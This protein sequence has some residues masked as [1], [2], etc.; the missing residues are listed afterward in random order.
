METGEEGEK[1][2]KMHRS[3]D[4]A[5]RS[6]NDMRLV[7]G[8]E[9]HT[10]PRTTNFFTSTLAADAKEELT[11]FGLLDLEIYDLLKRSAA[12]AQEKKAAGGE[13]VKDDVCESFYNEKAGSRFETAGWTEEEKQQQQKLL[14][15]TVNYLELPV[16]IK[17]E[18]ANY[19]GLPQ[20]E[21]DIEFA[22]QKVDKVDESRVKLVLA[23]LHD[24]GK[25]EIKRIR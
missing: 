12:A 22:H 23:D 8:I 9:G 2:E 17:D 5:Q 25:K 11:D 6:R 10:T 18:E 7:E 20:R 19:I 21:L 15:D 13:S 14:K 1:S 16:V 24:L 4:A 3:M